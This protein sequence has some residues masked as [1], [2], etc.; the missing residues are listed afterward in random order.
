MYLTVDSRGAY[1]H[2]KD[3]M[4]EI[5]IRS[6]VTE[7]KRLFA[8]SKITTLSIGQGAA[9]SGAAAELALK[10]NIDIIFLDSFEHPVG[11]VWFPGLGSTTKIR[12]AQ[13]L[14]SVNLEG[15]RIAAQWLK[16]KTEGRL[17]FIVRLKKHRPE[18]RRLIDESV[19]ILKDGIEKFGNFDPKLH[20]DPQGVLR[21][22]EGSQGRIYFSLLGQ[23]IPSDFKFEGRS[24]RPAKDHFNAFLNYSYGVLYGKIEKA[25]IIAGIDP[26]L[27]F[28]H[29]D[30]Y[31]MLSMVY[32]FVEPFRV[33]CEE[34]VFK[35]FSQKKA[36]LKH[37]DKILDGFQ[38]NKEGKMLLLE[39]LTKVFTENKQKYRNRSQ[40]VDNIIRLEA[41]ATAMRL[42]KLEFNPSDFEYIFTSDMT[43]S[44]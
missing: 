28:L 40:A 12:K 18:K 13:L 33:Y 14:A 24:M 42:L 2:V 15:L 6:G 17:D 16:A 34:A 27:G 9:L 4:F 29:R 39:E 35:L 30:D 31:N 36:A 3:N 10:Y 19:S 44:I 25:L 22:M 5:I 37:A 7:Q 23:L 21:G 20:D 32:D 43:E 26:Y 8:P 38:L 1:I 41:H 11:R